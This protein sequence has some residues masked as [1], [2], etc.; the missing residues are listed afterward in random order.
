M[1]GP[2]IATDD[3]AVKVLTKLCHIFRFDLH[4]IIIA[5]VQAI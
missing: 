1:T 3:E 5:L 2:I 4:P